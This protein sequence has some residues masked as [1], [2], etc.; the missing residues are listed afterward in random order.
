MGL[1]WVGIADVLKPV[2]CN[3]GN[4]AMVATSLSGWEAVIRIGQLNDLVRAG[5]GLAA[6]GKIIRLAAIGLESR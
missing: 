2:V 6:F 1:N 5:S 4:R 3:R